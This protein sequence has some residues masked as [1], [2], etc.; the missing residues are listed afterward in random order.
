MCTPRR[1]TPHD[2][3]VTTFKA[4]LSPSLFSPSQAPYD[5]F[6]TYTWINGQDIPLVQY[7]NSLY[8]PHNCLT[9]EIPMLWDFLEHYRLS[10][11]KTGLDARYCSASAFKRTIRS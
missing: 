10:G 1:F 6:E 11:T 4:C 8:R 3:T 9:S 5:R 2:G 7:T